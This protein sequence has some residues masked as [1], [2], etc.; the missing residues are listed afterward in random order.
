MV[1]GVGGE[2]DLVQGFSR[3]EEKGF[4]QNN[5]VLEKRFA[6]ILDRSTVLLVVIR[7][8]EE[9]LFG[10]VLQVLLGIV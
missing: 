8:A 4:T 6:P 3:L 5:K 1:L 7:L 10:G 2:E 9:R